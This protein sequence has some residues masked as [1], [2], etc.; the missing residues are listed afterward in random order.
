MS[1]EYPSQ[2]H[3]VIKPAGC[4]CGKPVGS[5]PRPPRYGATPE[6]LST[7]PP[8]K[9]R[10]STVPAPW[11][12]PQVPAPPECSSS[13]LKAT[14]LICEAQL[15]FAALQKC[16]IWVFSLGWMIK[17]IWALFSLLFIFLW[18]INMRMHTRPT[19]VC[20]PW[21][22]QVCRPWP[23]QARRPPQ[24]RRQMLMCL[25]GGIW[26]YELEPSSR[27]HS[28]T[29]PSSASPSKA[30]CCVC[31]SRAPPKSPRFQS[32]PPRVRTS[33]VSPVV[34]ASAPPS[35]R[36][37][38]VPPWTLTIFWGGWGKPTMAHRVPWSAMA[39]RVPWP[40]MA[41][42][43]PCSAVGPGTGSAL[44]AS[45]PRVPWGLQRSH[46]PPPRWMLHS[47]GCA[48]GEGGVM[49]VLSFCVFCFLSSH[50]HIWLVPVPVPV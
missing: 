1:G 42:R 38:W 49:S 8:C 10:T 47:T 16:I 26:G 30:L 9:A 44:E 29:A 19:Q 48:F 39:S 6:I 3:P 31:V 24:A 15:S 20:H 5:S 45:C 22:T 32:A 33:R 43:A 40:T 37:S 2:S 13:F 11:Q 27:A 23:T 12:F 18:N 46:L 34:C 41:S 35:A 50:G 17:V 14:S 25:A 7:Y 28:S 21:T 4:P 36:S